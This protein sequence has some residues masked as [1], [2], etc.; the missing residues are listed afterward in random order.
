MR[1]LKPSI[2]VM[3]VDDAP[4]SFHEDKETH[5]F[6]VVMRAPLYI[7][8]ITHT[9]VSIDKNDSTDALLDMLRDSRYISQVKA[10]ILDGIALG[11]FN[12]VDIDRLGKELGLNVIVYTRKRPDMG[13]IEAALKSKFED[14]TQR[15]ELMTC[16]EIKPLNLMT[17]R[18]AHTAYVQHTQNIEFKDVR[19]IL[20]LFIHRSTI[21]EP[22]RVAHLIGA[23]LELGES[24]GKA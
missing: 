19:D 13:A 16:H 6:G 24:K 20:K 21:P 7:E 22:V 12:V 23:G 3:G 17:K 18:G 1:R 2:R 10:M 15:L 14:W 11:G 5:V 9:T 8:G 4:F